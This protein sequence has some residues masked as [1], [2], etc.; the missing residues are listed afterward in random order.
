MS[1]VFTS[2]IRGVTALTGI[3]TLF[4][5]SAVG[6]VSFL[7]M[8]SVYNHGSLLYFSKDPPL[9]PSTVIL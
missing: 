9:C 6:I 4:A 2:C 7:G 8:S 3:I 5:C 1:P